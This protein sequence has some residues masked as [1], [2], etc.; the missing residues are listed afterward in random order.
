[1]LGVFECDICLRKFNIVIQYKNYKKECSEENLMF[2]DSE[3]FEEKFFI[4]NYC[5]FK[6]KSEDQFIIYKELYNIVD[7]KCD[8][9]GKVFFEG[10]RLKNYKCDVYDKF[11]YFVCDICGKVFISIR[12]LYRYCVCVYK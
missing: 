2:E 8:E 7:F 1:M 4:C 3:E 12:Y 10:Y 6:F 9:C 5:L 11:K